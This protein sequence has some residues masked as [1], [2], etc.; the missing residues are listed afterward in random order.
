MRTLVFLVVALLLAAVG[1]ARADEQP[2][3]ITV[4]G[5]G[6][7][8][9]VPDMAVITLGVTQEAKEARA[10]LSATSEAVGRVL[11]RLTELG[12]EA[13]DMQTSDLS[14]GPVWSHRND[15]GENRI[16][17]YEASNRLTVRVRALDSLGGVLDAVLEDGAN[18]FSGLQFGMQ[19]PVPLEDD[20]RRAAVA[21]ALRKA[22]LYAEAAGVPLG[23]VLSISENGVSAPMMGDMMFAAR[24]ES[25]PV[26]AG[27]AAISASVSVVFSLG[28]DAED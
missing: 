14:L 13:R 16:T 22:R 3:Q 25:V 19:D 10:A 17:G 1:L 11:D 24:A 8:E 6:V 21:D 7:V 2:G 20:A 12:I 23:D 9:T 26:A 18:R 28:E 15:G 5:T 27:E 4:T